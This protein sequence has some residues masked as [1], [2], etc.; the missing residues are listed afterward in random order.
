[1]MKTEFTLE[2]P[3]VG[4]VDVVRQ[5]NGIGDDGKKEY[6]WDFFDRRG[7]CLNEGSPLWSKPTK[8]DVLTFFAGEAK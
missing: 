3:G 8:K 2:I 7:S 6:F 5:E 1:M 4:K